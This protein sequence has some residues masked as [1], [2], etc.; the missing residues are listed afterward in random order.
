MAQPTGYI[1]SSKPNYVRTLTKA[2][3]DYDKLLEH[4][5]INLKELYFND[6]FRI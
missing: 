2:F 6:A 4:G 3:M 5:L 1:D